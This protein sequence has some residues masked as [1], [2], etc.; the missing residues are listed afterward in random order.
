M[1]IDLNAEESACDNCPVPREVWRDNCCS[2][3]WTQKNAAGIPAAMIAESE[4]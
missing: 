4:A 3:K 2:G 1:L